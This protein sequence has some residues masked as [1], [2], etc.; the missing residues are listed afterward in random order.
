MYGTTCCIE[1]V[2]TGEGPQLIQAS[3]WDCAE[4]LPEIE[5]IKMKNVRILSTDKLKSC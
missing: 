2:P 4:L 5:M 1:S 3:N